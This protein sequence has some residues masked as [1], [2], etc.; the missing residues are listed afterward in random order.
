MSLFTLS[1]FKSYYLDL[2]YASS[3]SDTAAFDLKTP[4]FDV[5]ELPEGRFQDQVNKHNPIEKSTYMTILFSVFP[6]VRAPDDG[7]GPA[8]EEPAPHRARRPQARGMPRR[9]GLQC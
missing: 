6:C 2:G 1:R 7:C 8:R 9:D 5:G 3:C 4:D